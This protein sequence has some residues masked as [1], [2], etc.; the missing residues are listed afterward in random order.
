MQ[1]WLYEPAHC[2][3]HLL[4]VFKV[5]GQTHR[6][7]KIFSC[8]PQSPLFIQHSV[9]HQRVSDCGLHGKYQRAI[10]K[11]I[12]QHSGLKGNICGGNG[13]IEL[14]NMIHFCL[15]AVRLLFCERDAD[16][17]DDGR[18]EPLQLIW[19]SKAARI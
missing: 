13:K 17:E 9:P 12:L 18:D 8:N 1:M 3:Q 4:Y 2:Q 16:S 5:K 11:I 6:R 10:Y 19:E 7:K 14:K 15:F